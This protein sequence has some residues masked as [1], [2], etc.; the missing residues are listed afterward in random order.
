MQYILSTQVE[1]LSQNLFS[2]T[3]RD[4]VRYAAN[5]GMFLSFE[6]WA[7]DGPEPFTFLD[8]EMRDDQLHVQSF[9]AFPADCTILKTQSIFEI[10]TPARRRH[11]E[12][13][14]S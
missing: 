3:H 9:H 6:E 8:Y 5:R 7:D 4:L 13:L 11:S 10:G 14:L 12:K 2:A 1:K